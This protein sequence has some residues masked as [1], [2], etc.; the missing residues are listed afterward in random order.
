MAE[1]TDAV[2]V[3]AGPAGCAFAA[4]FAS[5]GGRVTLVDGSGGGHKPCGG[6][7]PPAPLAETVSGAL[8][9]TEPYWCIPSRVEFQTAGGQ[10]ESWPV[11]PDALVV[12]SRHRL[13][14][15]LR[16]CAEESGARLV[17][18]R[19]TN[20]HRAGGRWRLL[21]GGT[22]LSADLL[23]GADGAARSQGVRAALGLPP[24]RALWARGS[25][26]VS[27]GPHLPLRV[28]A[29]PVPGYCWCFPGTEVA[30]LGYLVVNRPDL[31]RPE[32]L[33]SFTQ[34]AAESAPATSMGAEWT[35]RIPCLDGPGM[36]IPAFGS[37]WALVGD[38]AGLGDPITGAGIAAALRSGALAAWA[39]RVG[40]LSG[41]NTLWWVSEAGESLA[42]SVAAFDA[43]MR[44][45]GAVGLAAYQE[46]L[47]QAF[48]GQSC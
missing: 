40:P 29:L 46:L 23:V 39:A 5:G 37:D 36:A 35:G 42:R 34:F 10:T 2:V 45:G 33:S 30:S 17:R 20:I 8:V 1:H 15:A 27:S 43:A 44:L 4:D 22:A 24:T 6:V 28:R 41:A 9:A 19:A 21:V 26:V 32:V 16:D 31:E 14:T 18:G 38:A 47:R 11:P 25:Y 48:G 7:F 3:G 13:D 12:C